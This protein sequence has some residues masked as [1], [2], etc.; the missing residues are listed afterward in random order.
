MET[1]LEIFNIM[2]VKGGIGLRLEEKEEDWRGGGGI[3]IPAAAGGVVVVVVAVLA[4]KPNRGQ[5]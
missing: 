2:C 5:I 4:V 3:G 1:S